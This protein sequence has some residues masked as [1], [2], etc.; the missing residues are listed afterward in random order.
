MRDQNDGAIAF[1]QILDVAKRRARGLRVD[2]ALPR[3]ALAEVP[4]V[5]GKH[6][7]NRDQENDDDANPDNGSCGNR[8]GWIPPIK[9]EGSCIA[10]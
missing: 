7:A 1:Q 9:N 4:A 10:A 6:D 3:A 2:R 5:E 8:H